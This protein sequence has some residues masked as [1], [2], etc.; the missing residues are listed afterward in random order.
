MKEELERFIGNLDIVGTGGISDAEALKYVAESLDY[1]L[2][3][4]ESRSLLVG[5]DFYDVH[6]FFSKNKGV[7]Y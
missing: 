4:G 1:T 3:D 2:V 7:F 6:Q 5:V